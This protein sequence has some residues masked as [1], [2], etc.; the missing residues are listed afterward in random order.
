M[1]TSVSENKV[2]FKDGNYVNTRT[3][4]WTGGVKA[5]KFAEKTGLEV[6]RKGRILV[7]N[8]MQTNYDNVYAIGD[9]AELKEEYNESLPALV[10]NAI[11]TGECAA[12]N[13]FADVY[14][15][16]KEELELNLH[17]VM[18]SI[19]NSYGVADTM[20]LRTSGVFAIMLK[21]LVNLHYLFTIAGFGIVFEYLIHH[22]LEKNYHTNIVGRELVRHGGAKTYAF[23][24]PAVRIFLGIMWLREGLHKL[25]YN[26]L[27]T[28]DNGFVWFAKDSWLANWW[29]TLAIDVPNPPADVTAGA[30]LMKLIGENTP[31]WYEWFTE[32]T[33]FNAPMLFQKLVVIIELGLGLAFIAGLFTFI[34]GIVSVG[35]MINFI[36]STGITVEQYWFIFASISCMSGSGRA[37]GLD[38]YVIPYLEK[39]WRYFYDN[40]GFKIALWNFDKKS[41]NKIS[42]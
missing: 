4:I 27:R 35:M 32:I 19:G 5:N 21:H 30:S 40:R 24:L 17:G 23:F 7:N 28:T 20:G 38:Q 16:E 42:A 2:E 10:E 15:K 8:Y 34:A 37:F 31:G 9:V 22:F 36:L 12:E 3:L 29:T 39:Q 25:G 6:N 41:N 1:I 26:F 18:V 11:Q 13:I 33:V 14:G